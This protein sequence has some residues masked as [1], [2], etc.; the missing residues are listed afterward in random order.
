[1]NIRNRCIVESSVLLSRATATGRMKS[2]GLHAP[3]FVVS[4]NCAE[5]TGWMLISGDPARHQALQGALQAM[6]GKV[7]YLGPQPER[8]AAFKL[9]GNLTLLGLLGILGRGGHRHDRRVQPV[10]AL[11]PRPDA[12]AAR[13]ANQQPRA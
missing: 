1:M 6:T 13:R 5:G 4:A 12:A 9:F 11:Q 10:R 8:A 2:V 7:I 3:V